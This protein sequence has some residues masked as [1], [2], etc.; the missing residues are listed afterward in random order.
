MDAFVEITGTGLR[1]VGYA[2]LPLLVL[3]LLVLAVPMPL[4]TPATLLSKILD[5]ISGIAMG[6]AVSA[7]FLGLRNR[8]STFLP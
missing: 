2:A 7:A 4:K 8:D 6:L 3:P 5:R 1:Y